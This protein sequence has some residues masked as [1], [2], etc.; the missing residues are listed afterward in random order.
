MAHLAPVASI[1]HQVST[2]SLDHSRGYGT[3]RSEGSRVFEAEDFD[4]EVGYT[5][6]G[7]F[8]FG[9]VLA[10]RERSRFDATA[11]TLSS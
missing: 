1:F 5:F 9:T 11:A 10:R 6:V 4:L 2:G 3:P 8:A 7:A